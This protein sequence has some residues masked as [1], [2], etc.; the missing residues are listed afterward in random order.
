[1]KQTK[2]ITFNDGVVKIYEVCNSAEAG[3]MPQQ[4]LSIKANLRYKERTVG[5]QR[6]YQALQNNIKVKYVLRCPMLRTVST[7]DIA[8]PNDGH[9]YKIVLIQYPEDIEPAVMDLTLEEVK[10]KYEIG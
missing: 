8:T 9:Q 7:Q 1:M 2:P 4:Q 6:H 10:A 5:L 3:G